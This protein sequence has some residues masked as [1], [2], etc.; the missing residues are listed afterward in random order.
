MK[1]F[2][3]DFGEI[4]IKLSVEEA[5]KNHVYI[6]HFNDFES[7][8]GDYQMTGRKTLMPVQDFIKDINLL[9]P[10]E[11]NDDIAQRLVEGFINTLK[12]HCATYG[13]LLVADLNTY[14]GEAVLVRKAV[15]N[16]FNF[17]DHLNEKTMFK[18]Y[19]SLAHDNFEIL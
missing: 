17:K 2:T 12:Y 14:A 19:V 1:E 4:Q 13:R 8:S 9:I 15:F 10:N 16:A 3:M 5:D 6:P 7:T 18:G 11:L